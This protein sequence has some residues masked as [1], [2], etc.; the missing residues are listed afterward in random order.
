MSWWPRISSTPLAAGSGNIPYFFASGGCNGRPRR[1]R[2]YGRT[3]A[4]VTAYVVLEYVCAK[5]EEAEEADEAALQLQ[6]RS[7]PPRRRGGKDGLS[8]RDV[9][10]GAKS[11]IL[12]VDVFLGDG[13]DATK[14]ARI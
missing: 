2:G 9:E 5:A 12:M 14:I 8:I 10:S 11:A 4:L 1:S 6:L 7:R 13:L 3:A